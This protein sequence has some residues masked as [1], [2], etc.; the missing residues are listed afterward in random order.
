MVGTPNI[1]ITTSMIDEFQSP[2]KDN[3]NTYIKISQD[4]LAQ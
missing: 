4:G 1:K 2:F 3:P